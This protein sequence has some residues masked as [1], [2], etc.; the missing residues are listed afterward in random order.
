MFVINSL[1]VF[2]YSEFQRRLNNDNNEIIKHLILN[3][4][5]LHS[6]VASLEQSI[7][8]YDRMIPEHF[9]KNYKIK[10]V[11]DLLSKENNKKLF[12][13][14]KEFVEYCVAVVEFS[15]KF[16]IPISLSLA[17]SKSESNF[18]PRAISSASAKGIMQIMPQT[19]ELCNIV[20]KK[21]NADIFYVRDNVFCG[22]W[23]LSYIKKMFD[24]DIS[25][26]IYSYNVGP[27][28]YK[29]FKDTPYIPQET[30][31]YYEKVLY[32]NDRY[33]ILIEEIKNA[34]I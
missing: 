22:I 28:F 24:N 20:F 23:Y 19:F 5:E 1:T 10:I 13:S 3:N 21:D 34:N 8:Q 26:A 11:I 7:A 17:V 33:N 15:E 14:E 27:G 32:F 2:G 12:K 30:L 29:K 4:N 18:N 31:N 9:K 16:N 25:S 6:K